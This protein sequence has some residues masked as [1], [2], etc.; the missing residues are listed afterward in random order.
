MMISDPRLLTV[1]GRVIYFLYD[2]DRVVA[3][4]WSLTQIIFKVRC[5]TVK[6]TERYRL[7]IICDVKVRIDR[8]DVGKMFDR[9]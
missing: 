2:Y 7:R 5:V 6:I 3:Q 4:E 9:I 1:C 8:I